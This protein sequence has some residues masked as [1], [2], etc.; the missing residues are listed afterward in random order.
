MHQVVVGGDPAL[1][2]DLPGDAEDVVLAV[3]RV[4]RR[5]LRQGE[6]G[7]VA[8]QG[9]GRLVERCRDEAEPHFGVGPH[10]L[11]LTGDSDRGNP[12]AGSLSMR[13]VARAHA[14]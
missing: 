13:L 8:E 1:L 14:Y 5:D 3:L 9:L 2:L 11:D 12:R 4:Q 6:A 10:A 7:G